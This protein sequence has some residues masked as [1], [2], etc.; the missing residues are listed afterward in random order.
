MSAIGTDRVRIVLLPGVGLGHG[1]L[2]GSGGKNDIFSNSS[3]V[4]SC[5]ILPEKCANSY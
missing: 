1:G 3:E 2:E 4:A 5:P